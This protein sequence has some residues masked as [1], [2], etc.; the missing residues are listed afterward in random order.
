MGRR[1][2]D[3]RPGFHC[4]NSI[5]SVKAVISDDMRK[6][7]DGLWLA[8]M[9]VTGSTVRQMPG[10]GMAPDSVEPAHLQFSQV[11]WGEQITRLKRDLAAMAPVSRATAFPFQFEP[12]T[13][14]RSPQS[15]PSI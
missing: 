10:Q 12:P 13:F 6:F 1:T 9:P 15:A 4:L 8:A 5:F 14:A 2:V 7:G 3:A 11:E